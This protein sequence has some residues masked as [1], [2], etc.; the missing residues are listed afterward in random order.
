[1][2]SARQSNKGSPLGK[3]HQAEIIDSTA[4]KN[5]GREMTIFMRD[6]TSKL[7]LGE[8]ELKYVYTNAD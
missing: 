5:N 3:N 8:S 2:E 6:F 7:Q 4:V 1:M